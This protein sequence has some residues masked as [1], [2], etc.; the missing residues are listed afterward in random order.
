MVRQMRISELGELNGIAERFFESSGFL[1]IFKMEIFEKNWTN[2]LE[3][4]IGVIFVLI[5]NEEIHGV[6]G[7]IKYPDLN[8]G[9][10][11]ATECFW[12]VDKVHR[13]RGL[14]L[15]KR[16]EKWAVEQECKK[17]IMVH[18]SDLMPDVVKK[19][20]ARKG[21]KEME[22]HYVKEVA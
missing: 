6:I 21:Y 7:G 20:Y 12:F 3:S 13:G 1:D 9:V 4:G 18:L 17:I 11:C 8:S 2:I 10:I 14:I 19:I 16:F 22:T 5:V 15:L